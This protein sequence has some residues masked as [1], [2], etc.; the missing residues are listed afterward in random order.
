MQG[1]GRD[2]DSG[3]PLYFFPDQPVTETRL[4]F[5]LDSGTRAERAWAHREP[6]RYGVGHIW[7]YIAREECARFSEFERTETLRAAGA[8]C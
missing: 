7:L 5:L 6:A 3:D 4:R 1:S 2:S 8:E